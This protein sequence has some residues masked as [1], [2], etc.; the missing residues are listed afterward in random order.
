MK[1]I[2]HGIPLDFNFWEKFE[3]FEL[4]INQRQKEDPV[5]GDMLNRIRVGCHTEED[6]EMLKLRIL[7]R[8]SLDLI[9]NTAQYYLATKCQEFNAVVLFALTD[10]VNQF[11]KIISEKF[12]KYNFIK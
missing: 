5:Y 7:P 1:E 9:V 4:T 2:F 10:H 12:G 6:V 11:N 8:E 3:Y